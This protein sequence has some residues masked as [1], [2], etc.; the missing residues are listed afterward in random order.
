[1]LSYKKFA[2][3]AGLFVIY[4]EDVEIYV[5]RTHETTAYF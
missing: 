1:M 5:Y 2:W 4:R 3:S